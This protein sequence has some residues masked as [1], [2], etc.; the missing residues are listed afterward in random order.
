MG[1]IDLNLITFWVISRAYKNEKKITQRYQKG[2]IRIK[3]IYIYIYICACV[4]SLIKQQNQHRKRKNEE[5]NKIYKTIKCSL[6]SILL[7]KNK[8]ND[9]S[10]KTITVATRRL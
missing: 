9:N 5:E 8:N 3:F 10:L 6:G 7:N 2:Y 1:F 4:F